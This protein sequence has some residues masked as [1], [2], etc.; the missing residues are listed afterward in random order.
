MLAEVLILATAIAPSHFIARDSTIPNSPV[1]CDFANGDRVSGTLGSISATRVKLSHPIWRG[2]PHRAPTFAGTNA[3]QSISA[4][5][6]LTGP[7]GHYRVNE[8]FNIAAPLTK[9]ASLKLG[10]TNRFDTRP[11]TNGSKNDTSIQSGIGVSSFEKHI[12]VWCEP[13]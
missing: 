13:D 12:S 11:Q 10:V 2:T 5:P 8:D 6:D 3:D 7:S 4:F 1:V 9:S